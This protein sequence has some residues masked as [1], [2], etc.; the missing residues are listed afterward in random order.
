MITQFTLTLEWEK[1]ALLIPLGLGG[2]YIVCV[3]I[4]TNNPKHLWTIVVARTMRESTIV[5]GQ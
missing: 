3:R 4:I 1:D 2:L 5:Q